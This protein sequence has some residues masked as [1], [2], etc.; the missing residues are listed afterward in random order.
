MDE[1]KARQKIQE[2]LDSGDLPRDFDLTGESLFIGHPTVKTCVG[3]GEPF[4]PDDSL[5]MAHTGSGQK[6]W[7]HQDCETILA[8]RAASPKTEKFKLNHYQPDQHLRTI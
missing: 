6:Y 5:T 2:N 7:F 3:C 4:S 1:A 8:G